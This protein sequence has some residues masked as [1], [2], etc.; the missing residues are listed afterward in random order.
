[1][2]SLCVVVLFAIAC[3]AVQVGKG[4]SSAIAAPEG[5]K[6]LGRADGDIETRITIAITQTNKDYLGMCCLIFII[7]EILI[8]L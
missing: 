7:W 8:E 1:M 2:K 3:S 4:H 5:W 6:M